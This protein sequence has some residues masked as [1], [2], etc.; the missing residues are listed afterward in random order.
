MIPA[1]KTADAVAVVPELALPEVAEPRRRS[2]R[3]LKVL[4][5]SLLALLLLTAAALGLVISRGGWYE[6]HALAVSAPPELPENEAAKQE[7]LAKKL[8]ELAPRGTYVLVDTY[9]NRV[10]VYK[11]GE[12]VREAVC[13][14]GSGTILKDPEKG[15]EWVFDTP[16]GE[17]KVQR[18]VKN[19]VWVKPDWAFI[20]EGY[21]PPARDSPDRYDDFSLGDY[22]LY[23]GDGYIIHGTVFQSLLGQRV[24]HGCIRMGDAD[25]EF[26]YKTVPIGTRVYLY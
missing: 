4:S 17:R 19:P 16:R 8:T 7:K 9:S 14:T 12:L 1:A 22:G 26:L 23:L 5:G 15:R 2:W 25:L 10:K 20:E 11:E 3:W 6:A 13:S 21:K 18:K 24:T